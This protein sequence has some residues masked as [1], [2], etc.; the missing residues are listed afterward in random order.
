MKKI[1]LCVSISL[2]VFL[3]VIPVGYTATNEREKFSLEGLGGVYLSEEAK[4]LLRENGFVVTP[5][6]KDEMN[7]VYAEC[8]ER[9]C[10][11]YLSYI[12]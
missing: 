6:Y 10:S 11:P 1:I 9:R 7:D 2:F 8:K 5:G 3:Q 12:L 4:E